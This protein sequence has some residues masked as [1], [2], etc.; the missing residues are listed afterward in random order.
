ML[1]LT[2]EWLKI[3]SLGGFPWGSFALSQIDAFYA[4]FTFPILGASGT[5]AVIALL[6]GLFA[7]SRYLLS[8]FVVL[9]IAFVAYPLERPAPLDKSW[10]VRA[11]QIQFNPKESGELDRA[12]TLLK[13]AQQTPAINVFPEGIV[14]ISS[15]DLEYLKESPSLLDISNPHPGTLIFGANIKSGDVVHNTAQIVSSHGKTD[16]IKKVHL[17]PFGE[18]TPIGFKWLGDILGYNPMFQPGEMMLPVKLNG[19]MVDIFICYDGFYPDMIPTSQ[20]AVMILIL[21][22]HWFRSGPLREIHF[23]QAK[24]LSQTYLKPILSVG[25]DGITGLLGPHGE[26]YHMAKKEVGFLS[27]Q[28]PLYSPSNVWHFKLFHQLVH[29]IAM[30]ML[31]IIPFESLCV[32]FSRRWMTGADTIKRRHSFD[33]TPK[34]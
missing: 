3:N 30:V 6:S 9:V 25:S 33:E 16:G 15:N 32:F 22:D 5:C 34:K 28:L 4:S 1:W 12:I 20:S 24:L 2:F 21:D 17:V 19:E 10:L 31:A 14:S 23:R 18:Q 27:T 13:N 7:S 29:T 8:L 11:Y 26:K